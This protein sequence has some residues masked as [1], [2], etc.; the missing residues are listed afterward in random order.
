[1][2]SHCVKPLCQAI[3]MLTYLQSTSCYDIAMPVHQY[4]RFF[5]NPKRSH[6]KAIIKIVQNLK[7]IKDKGII[8]N[9]YKTHG[10]ECYVDASFAPEWKAEDANNASNLLSR[11][12]FIIC[13]ALVPVHWCSKTQSDNILST[14][15]SEYLALSQAM[16]EPIPFM[17]LMAELDAVFPLNLPKMKVV[18]QSL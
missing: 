12:G 5:N 18:L 16:R 6:E 10:I 13:Y 2:P 3:G 8:L 1:M 11:T 4:A 7:G 14:A 15:E 17:R 9:A